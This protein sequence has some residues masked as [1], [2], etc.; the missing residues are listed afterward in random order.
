MVNLLPFKQK[1]KIKKEYKMRRA[2]VALLFVGVLF[3]VGIVFLVPQYVMLLNKQHN[4]KVSLDTIKHQGVEKHHTGL[5]DVISKTNA[6]IKSLTQ[7]SVV[8]YGAYD[9]FREVLKKKNTSIKIFGL[10]YN[11]DN[12]ETR[13]SISGIA[14]DRKNLLAFTKKLESNKM[15]YGVELPISNFVKEQDIDFSILIKVAEIDGS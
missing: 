13:V 12:N 6:Q 5:V 10:F 4:L 3:I 8:F 15:F 9:V 11:F 7:N 2:I 1:Q 14:G